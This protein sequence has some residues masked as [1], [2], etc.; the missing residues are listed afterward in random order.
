MTKIVDG[1]YFKELLKSGCANL[2][3]HQKEINALNV[4]PVPDGDTGTN[5]S[6]T[7]TNGL[8]DALACESDSVTDI[9]KALSKGL[10]MGARGNSGVITSRIFSGLYQH[11]EGKETIEVADLAKG[12]ENGARVAY[13]AIMKPVEGTI[14]TVVREGSWYANHD[15]EGN[16]EMSVEEYFEAL[17]KY[18]QESL[19]HTPDLLPVLKEVGVVD[20]GGAGLLKIIEGFKACA[21][22]NPFVSETASEKASADDDLQFAALEF[23]NDE[24]GYC[25]EFILRLAEDQISKFN[26]IAFRSR[27]SAIG[28]SLVV[29]RD[30][31][32]VKVHV[33]TLTPGEALNIGQNYGEFVKLKIENMQEQHSAI[34]RAA[35]KPQLVDVPV[36]KKEKQKFGIIT[37]AA[38]AG[39]HKVFKDLRADVIING[40]QTMNPSTEDF[41]KEIE[42]L[43][44]DHI[45]I[46]PNNSN[47][48]LA[49]NQAKDICDDRDITVLTTKT[50][51]EGISALS[52]FNPENSLEENITEMENARQNVQSGSLTYAV[53]D[54]S[55]DGVHVEE[56]DFIGMTNK[57]IVA[58]GKNKLEVVQKLIDEMAKKDD[59][60]L[61]TIITGEDANESETDEIVAYI[62]ENTEMEADVVKGDQPVYAYLFGVE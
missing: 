61:I 27:L 58:S 26:E 42:K 54:T 29:A 33:H 22:G 56:G 39:L 9:A 41:A 5:M 36:A 16:P 25:T 1:A 47:I 34:E 51:P 19:E 40:G 4:F 43:N 62:E 55:L 28:N 50:I 23:E 11:I 38:G 35:H 10:L 21:L 46:L 48:I 12:F 3:N 37:V 30:E 31:E 6:M 49:A 44:A 57:S 17:Y 15:F 52:M 8:K 18:M 2:T 32:L 45:I 24:F 59:A 60:E 7:F 14:L 13:R 53:R 20:S